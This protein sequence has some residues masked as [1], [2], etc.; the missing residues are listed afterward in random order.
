[1][2]NQ[3]NQPLLPQVKRFI[4]FRSRYYGL[5]PISSIAGK[6]YSEDLEEIL[7][8]LTAWMKHVNIVEAV[9]PL[10]AAEI[11][12]EYLAKLAKKNFTLCRSTR[13]PGFS[14][15][16]NK[17]GLEFSNL[18]ANLLA[19]GEKVRALPGK[20]Y[21]TRLGK[22]L[23]LAKIADWMES[24]NLIDAITD[25]CDD[26]AMHSII[27]IYGDVTPELVAYA[28]HP[29]WC[30]PVGLENYR[31]R[32]FTSDEVYGLRRRII[33]AYDLAEMCIWALKQYGAYAE[34]DGE[35]GY[36][37]VVTPEATSID[38]RDVNSSGRPA[39]VIPSTYNLPGQQKTI[40]ELLSLMEHEIQGHVRQSLTLA[41]VFGFGGLNLKFNAETNYE[42]LG[43]WNDARF[44]MSLGRPA[45]IPQPWYTLGIHLAR[46]GKGFDE[47]FH[48]LL[49]AKI[50]ASSNKDPAAHASDVYRTC[51]RIFR[52][53]SDVSRNR[54]GY[55]FTKDLAYLAGFLEMKQLAE[56]DLE[57]YEILANASPYGL[58]L[59]RNLEIDS[60]FSWP[61]PYQSGLTAEYYSDVLRYT[62]AH[63]QEMRIVD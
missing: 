30:K 27:N 5:T 54:C 6:V 39:I 52:G 63:R 43:K 3:Y 18:S 56:Y 46:Q 40:K 31:Q 28:Q 25:K 55:A 60:E 20:D 42:S 15:E 34:N 57:H 47:V 53:C 19:A 24:V 58:D 35:Y 26:I 62:L 2:T 45:S 32:Q 1:M 33:N 16:P 44:D 29:D 41:K 13:H 7:E 48:A 4:E 36:H 14:Y 9:E 37:V 22:Q 50:A 11:K 8:P 21:A 51:Q 23:A 10:H 59:L 61:Y 17:T 12:E 38:V 49:R